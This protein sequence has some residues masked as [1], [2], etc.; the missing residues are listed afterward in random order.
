MSCI[1]FIS[2]MA[3][4]YIYHHLNMNLQLWRR[5]RHAL[6]GLSYFPIDNSINIIIKPELRKVNF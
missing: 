4:K 5:R 3:I 2:G 6:A 1:K